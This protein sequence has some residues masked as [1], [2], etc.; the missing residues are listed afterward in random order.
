MLFGRK[1][2]SH[3]RNMNSSTPQAKVSE[4]SEYFTYPTKVIGIWSLLFFFCSVSNPLFMAWVNPLQSQNLYAGFAV[5]QGE[6]PYEDFFGTGGVLFYLLAAVG[7]V[8]GV[9]LVYAVIQFFAV[10]VSGCLFY[11]LLYHLSQDERVSRGLLVVFYGLLFAFGLGG[12]Y[13]SLLALPFA[14]A[15][16]WFLLQYFEGATSDEGFIAYGLYAAFAFLLYPKTLLL[17]L[18]ACPVLIYYHIQQKR[19]ARGFYQFLASLFG[20]LVLV[21]MVGYY[22]FVN[23]ILTAGLT[24]VFGVWPEGT[25]TLGQHTLL[26]FVLVLALG[27][28][29]SLMATLSR[30]AEP[31]AELVWGKAIIVL[32][33]FLFILLKIFERDL[34]PAMFLPLLP[35]LVFLAVPYVLALFDKAERTVT[36]GGQASYLSQNAVWKYM[37][38]NALAPGFVL[39]FAFFSFYQAS[40]PSYLLQAD[41]AV[42]AD[43]LR[44]QTDEQARIYAWDTDASLYVQSQRLSASSL[45]TPDLAMVHSE[46]QKQ[47]VADLASDKAQYILVNP[48][49]PLLDEVS[50]VLAVAYRPVTDLP[51]TELVLYQRQ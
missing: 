31:K 13:A 8:F 3:K 49:L 35:Y 39:A 19:Y 25:Y 12:M 45:V 14:L 36:Y 23:Q 48:H 7:Q 4:K 2:K 50:D 18:A 51:T 33:T 27:G 40:A 5:L 34:R 16:L 32:T 30:W 28:G 38:G 41:R 47:L 46:Q 43:Y 29:T 24:Q 15:G 11:R 1:S 10:Y 6:V 42:I 37:V 22:V 17:W 9:G 20:F 21:Y 44:H 26:V